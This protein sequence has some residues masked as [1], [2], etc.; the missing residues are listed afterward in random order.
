MA[1]HRK[2]R[3]GADRWIKETK[4]ERKRG[5]EEGEGEIGVEERREREKNESG[6]E[7]TGER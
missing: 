3:N 7:R 5:T 4:S 6:S 2:R 1:A